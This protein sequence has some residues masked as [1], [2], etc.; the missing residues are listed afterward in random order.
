MKLKDLDTRHFYFE[1]NLPDL[2]EDLYY[3][4]KGDYNEFMH[5]LYK[6]EK[7]D[8]RFSAAQICQ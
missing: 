1:T 2:V 6:R 3:T 5:N 4:R 7:A 8:E